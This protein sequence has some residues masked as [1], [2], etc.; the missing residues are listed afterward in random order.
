MT[1]SALAQRLQAIYTRRRGRIRQDLT[2]IARLDEALGFPSRSLRTVVVAGTNGKGTCAR[3]L[4]SIA[5][6]HGLKT[7]LFTSPHRSRLNQRY[8]IDG[9]EVDDDTLVAS[10]E[11]VDDGEA[12]FFE[13][14]TALAFDLFAQAAVDLAVLEVGMGGRWDAVNQSDPEVSTV[15]S[16]ALDHQEYLGDSLEQIAGEKLAVARPARPL[17]LGPGMQPYWAQAQSTD[18]KLWLN[19]KDWSVDRTS[20][21]SVHVIAHRPETIHLDVLWDAA[22]TGVATAT[23]LGMHRE[24]AIQK[25][26]DDLRNP[27]RGERVGGLLMD[28]AH[29]EAAVNALATQVTGPV[30]ALVSLCGRDPR[31]LA[32]FL[33]VAS[34]VY[35]VEADHPKA[36][37]S[38]HIHQVLTGMGAEVYVLTRAEA[39][40]RMMH[41]S[42]RRELELVAFGSIYGLGP[43]RDALMGVES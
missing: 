18:A 33:A 41:A 35:V 22:A 9:R 21:R 10:I 42:Q 7:G 26:L 17:V 3:T 11:R 37:P 36:V 16:V 31:V 29:N 12:T 5:R 4:E 19:G 40:E 43:L 28:A 24:D 23:C 38:A 30:D 6:A 1:V 8:R 15:T 32:P 39:L 34:R 25:G 20:V 13:L 2:G 27:M 14:S